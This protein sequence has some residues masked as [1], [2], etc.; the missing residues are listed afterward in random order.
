M[1]VRRAPVWGCQGPDEHTWCGD[2]RSPSGDVAESHGA[3][4]RISGYRTYSSPGLGWDS[5]LTNLWVT[6]QIAQWLESLFWRWVIK[7]FKWRYLIHQGQPETSSASLQTSSAGT[8]L[9]PSHSLWVLPVPLT[10]KLGIIWLR[11]E[12]V[13]P[14]LE[15]LYSVGRV[16]QPHWVPCGHCWYGQ[17]CWWR[18][19][20]PIAK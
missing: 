11:L 16:G 4:L 13:R 20:W 5:L 15:S 10:G 18:A 7:L 6:C 14:F 17:P 3:H 9:P 8:V 1:A 12:S 2:P 19:S